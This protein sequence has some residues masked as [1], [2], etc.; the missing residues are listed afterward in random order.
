MASVNKVI[1]IGNLGADPEVRYA[2]NGSQVTRFNIATRDFWT[3]KEGVREEKTQWNRIVAF[4]NLAKI[5]GD[6]LS[7][8]RL[9]YIEGRL[10]TRSWDDRD[11]NKRV[12]TEVVAQVMQMLGP[13]GERGIPKEIE[14]ESMSGEGGLPPEDDIPF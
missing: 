3:T 8:G 5:C 9:V 1:L 7:K 14:A 11:G 2:A 6:Y 4:G 13:A 10:Q 12:T